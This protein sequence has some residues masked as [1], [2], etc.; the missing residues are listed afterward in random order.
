MELIKT[1]AGSKQLKV[2][3]Y[4]HADE[5]NFVKN[6]RYINQSIAI[7][8]CEYLKASQQ[9]V[10]VEE[11]YDSQSGWRGQHFYIDKEDLSLNGYCFSSTSVEMFLE[12]KGF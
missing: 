4:N 3:Q 1:Y 9:K 2:W 8:L 11:C 10:S 7:R 5:L 12:Q 6:F